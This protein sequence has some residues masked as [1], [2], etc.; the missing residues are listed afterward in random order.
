[1]LWK[2]AGELTRSYSAALGKPT[3]VPRSGE[4]ES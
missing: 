2:H 3:V 1:M 4:L